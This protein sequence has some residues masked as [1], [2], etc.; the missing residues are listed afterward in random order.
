[1]EHASHV[2]RVLTLLAMAAEYEKQAAAV[3][4]RGVAGRPTRF[5]ETM[6]LLDLGLD[7]QIADLPATRVRWQRFEGNLKQLGISAR[8]PVMVG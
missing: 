3:S 8:E 1:V 4:N 6:H 2:E 7:T 5:E